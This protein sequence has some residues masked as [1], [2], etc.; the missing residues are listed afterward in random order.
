MTLDRDVGAA[1]LA[2]DDD[3]SD[4]LSYTLGGAD[5]TSFTIDRVTNT[6]CPVENRGG[7]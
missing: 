1:I 7:T 3:S 5:A 6:E 2:K 4:T